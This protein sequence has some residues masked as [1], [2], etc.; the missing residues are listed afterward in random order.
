MR[1]RNVSGA[2]SHNLN[3]AQ[4]S[5]QTLSKG[6]GRALGQLTASCLTEL[7]IY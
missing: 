5:A 1:R 4:H 3:C 7:C 2:H 6:Q